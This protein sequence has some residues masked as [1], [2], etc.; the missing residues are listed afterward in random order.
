MTWECALVFDT[1]TTGLVKT[2]AI[3]ID[4]QPRIIEY[5][6]ALV[7]P[8]GD[9]I[10]ELE[11]MC[12]PGI[13]LE[14]I[15]TKITGLTDKDL[16]DKPSFGH[17]AGELQDM[18]GRADR[19]VAHNLS[20]DR[21]LVEFDGQRCSTQ[22]KFPSQRCCTVEQTMHFFGHRL[23]LTKLHEHLFDE[24]FPNAHRA[25]NDVAAL[26]RCYMKLVEL[27]TV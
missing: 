3:P 27:E 16:A 7:N 8:D 24:G 22:F 25:R 26:I 19:I 15:I 11:F 5:Y 10:D 17:Y 2:V 12:N 20:F 1:E 14:P 18:M 13:M 6:G 21:D 4:Q 23:S 9:I